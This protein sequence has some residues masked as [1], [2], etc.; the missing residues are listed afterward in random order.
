MTGMNGNSFAGKLLIEGEIECL[1]GLH[2]GGNRETSDIGGV[3]LLVIRDPVTREPYIPGSSLKGKLRSLLERYRHA[4]E[5][6]KYRF[7]RKM[8][9]GDVEVHLHECGEK[10]C[11]ICRLFGVSRTKGIVENNLPAALYV[12]DAR[13]TKASRQKLS[14]MESGYYLT[15]VKFENALDRITCAANPRQIERVPRGAQFHFQMVYNVWEKTASANME[16]DVNEIF[17]GLQL[18]EDDY[19]GGHGSRG[20]GQVRFVNLHVYWRSLEYYQGKEEE[21]AWRAE[22]EQSLKDVACAVKSWLTSLH[23][24]EERA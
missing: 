16:E 1:T 9:V 11:V 8:K 23:Q 5:P 15:E 10:T 4:L 13:L 22:P 7:I 21:Q 18:L 20:Y 12:R 14:E 2:I 24:P 6:E 19:L 17:T 3:D